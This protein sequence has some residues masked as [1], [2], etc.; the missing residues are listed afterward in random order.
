MPATLTQALTQLSAEEA[1][2]LIRNGETVTFSGFTSAGTPKA[3]PQAL[4]RVA[5]EE[6]EAGRP[7]RIGVIT[8]A[9]TTDMLDGA[10]ARAK[11]I[12]FRTP[13][14]SD[15]ALRD[16][17]NHGETHFFD[18]HLSTLPQSVRYG[19]LGKIHWAIL[20]A[21]EVTPD[22]EITLTSGVGAAP[23][24]ARMADKVI[25][26]LNRHYPTTLYGMHDLYEP[27]DPPFRREIPIFKPSDRIGAKTIKI[28]PAKIAGIVETNFPDAGKPFAEP[29]AVTKKIGENVAEFLAAEIRA[30]RIP[31]QFLPIQSG[32]GNIANA[33]LG[34]MGSHPEIPPFQMYTEVV[35]DS[36]VDLMKRDRVTFASTCSLTLS[37]EAMRAV[38]A[39]VNWFRHRML[40]RPQELSNNPEIIRRLGLITINTAIEADFYGNVN[41]THVMGCELMNGIGGSGDFTRNAYVS[42]F[43]CPSTAKGGKITT[44]VP[45]VAHVDQNEHSVKVI[46][47]ENGVADLRGLDPRERARLIIENCAHPSFRP[48]LESYLS[49]AHDG[50]TPFNPVAAY[51]LHR[52]YVETGDMHGVNW[53]RAFGF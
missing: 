28:D 52:Q 5:Q 30:D 2:R 51:A 48:D 33:V 10:L 21:G 37:A 7:F 20:E 32:V 24:F 35:Q 42:I 22:G 12:S 6:H 26:E 50:R 8:G 25:I 43:T 46:I 34:A 16:A 39:D 11:A 38:Y 29:N 45:Q 41:S 31:L 9:S 13:Y 18:L 27:A 3:V 44:I 4:G 47:T 36:V 15:P 17:I 53:D 14:Q 49:R 23:T 40:M 1:A 19:F